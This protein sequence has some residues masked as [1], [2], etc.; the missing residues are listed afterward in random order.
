[1]LLP[2]PIIVFTLACSLN[3]DAR[4]N[5]HSNI[6]AVENLIIKLWNIN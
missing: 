3:F 6:T 4:M 5:Q 1:M 2:L